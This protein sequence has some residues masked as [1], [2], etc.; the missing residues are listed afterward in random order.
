MPNP[1]LGSIAL[2]LSSMLIV[3]N[4]VEAEPAFID[5]TAEANL[6]FVSANG[7]TFPLGH[8]VQ[9]IMQRNMGNGAA[10]GDYDNDGD[11]DVYLL[12]P[13]GETNR[14]FRNDLD[15][16][17]KSFTDVTADACVG[18][19]GMSRTAHFIDLDNN[20]NLDLLLLNDS[21]GSDD[22]PASKV[23]RNNGDG[24]FADVS[25]GSGFNPVGYLRC[26]A[27]L[28]D[29]DRD[30]LLDVYVTG[31][32][33][34]IGL[35]SPAFPGSNRLYR[36]LGNFVFQ[37]V[38][39]AVGLDG[40][41]RDSF[42]AIFTDFN[43]DQ[44][45]DLYVAVD[46]TSDEFYWNN[47]GS[48]ANATAAVN[49]THVGNDMGVAC[50]DFDD[51]GDLDLYTTNITDLSP[52]SFPFGTNTFNCLYEWEPLGHPSGKFQD[53]AIARGCEDTYWGWGVDF[54][55]VENDGDL[56]IFA[57]TGFEEFISFKKSLAY[58]IART[59]NVL[60]V[61]DGSGQYARFTASGL[62][63]TNDSRA[64]IAFDYDRDGDLDLLT[65][66]V[67]QPVELLENVSSPQGHWL[68][69]GIVQGPGEN[70]DGIG[71]TVRATVGS[72]T[73]RRD[74]LAGESYLAGTPAEARFGLGDSTVIDELR[75]EWTD[76]TEAVFHNVAV[77]RF[78][79]VSSMA[80]DCD[81]NLNVEINDLQGFVNVLLDAGAT[82]LCVADM[83]GDGEMNS[84]DIPLFVA[85][86]LA[87]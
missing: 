29:Y 77:D 53:R 25:A 48:F 47:A 38:T 10:V 72:V 17:M 79:R 80:G 32:H 59:P 45:P 11:L 78:V 26:G 67:N 42:T 73:K 35:G 68:G 43:D 8:T 16:G 85:A 57:V 20:G 6:N 64:L 9:E 63:S 39:T 71:V 44:Y 27:A 60:L 49:T 3:V 40:L 37:D 65:T 84:L 55:D 13:L 23:F 41:S 66:N 12:A 33:H 54:L 34:E 15:L 2:A 28:A 21:D 58:S 50:A 19:W 52:G 86:L 30:G 70:R 24:T 56:D 31:W 69:V 87:P 46:H 51:D 18:D 81:A 36:N 22:Y 74:I 5:V 4:L 14:L 76:G 83:N 75:I 61:N 62:T 7:P 82:S 1:A